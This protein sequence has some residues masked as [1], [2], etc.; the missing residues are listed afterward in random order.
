MRSLLRPIAIHGTNVEA[1]F[2]GV[3]PSF[4]IFYKRTADFAIVSKNCIGH[5]IISMVNNTPTSTC[6]RHSKVNCFL[7]IPLKLVVES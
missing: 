4:G 2:H 3:S 1:A 7:E 6:L 5:V